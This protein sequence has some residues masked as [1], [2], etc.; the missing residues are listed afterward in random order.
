MSTVL[1]VLSLVLCLATLAL[2][3][4]SYRWGMEA[5]GTGDYYS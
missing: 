4:L 1:S 3:R 2:W 5:S